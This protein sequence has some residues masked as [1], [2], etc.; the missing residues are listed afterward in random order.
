M[1]WIIF[2]SPVMGDGIQQP[3]VHEQHVTDSPP[4]T[5]R[6]IQPRELA[7]IRLRQRVFAVGFPPRGGVVLASLTSF[8]SGTAV[9]TIV[10]WDAFY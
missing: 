2:F 1:L 6:K 8:S 10:L 4:F 5:A 7:S 3:L 9:P